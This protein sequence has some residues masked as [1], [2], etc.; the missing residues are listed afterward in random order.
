[1]DFEERLG[2]AIKRGE[3]RRREAADEAAREAMS[4]QDCQRIHADYRNQLIRRIEECLH[5]V[6]DRFPGFRFETI[7]DEQGWGAR[8]SRDDLML[9][10]NRSRTNYFSRL[11]LLVRPYSSYH[12]LDLAAKATIRNR[13]LFNRSHYKPL[14][15]IDVDTFLELIDIWS[16][17]FA[18]AFSSN[19]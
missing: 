3:T 19:F 14:E 16:I 13:K 12:V 4:E 1:M 2:K 18:E 7:V 15:E 6:A 8:I 17:E 10:A 5:A 11:Q 9:E